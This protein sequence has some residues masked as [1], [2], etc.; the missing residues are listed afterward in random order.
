MIVFDH[1]TKK[2]TR[3]H[4]A[5]ND[6]TV[7]IPDGEFVFLVGPSGAGKTT[8]L[9]LLLRDLL[10]TTG[11]VL[12]DDIEVNKI[13]DHRVHLLRRKAGMVF[14]DFKLL[15]DQTVYENVAIA[16]EILGKKQATIEKDVMDILDLVGLVNKKNLFPQQLAAGELQRVSIARAIVGGP[17]MLLADEPTGNLDPD[18][19]WD[20]IRILAEINK[21]G[22]TVIMA[23]HNVTI[24]DQLGKRTIAIRDGEIKSDEKKGQYP[25]TKKEKRIHGHP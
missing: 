4:A 1:V 18:T 2:F 16:L 21:I 14:Q 13:P 6:I 10:P 24:V 7:E 19:S 5:L 23:T 9:R 25:K 12:I 11:K 8:M 22:T 15:T 3:G 17:R 20:I